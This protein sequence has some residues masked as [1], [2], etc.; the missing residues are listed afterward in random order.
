MKGSWTVF[1][2]LCVAFEGV[3]FSQGGGTSAGRTTPAAEQPT[4]NPL[5]GDGAA[6]RSGGS[7][8]RTRCAG[9]HGVD[10]AGYIGPDLTRL[11]VQGMIDDR[12]FETVRKGV[13]GTDMPPADPR[14][15]PDREIWE[16]LAYLRSLTPVA[17]IPETGNAENGQ[18][19]F[20]RNCQFCHMVGDTGGQLGPE[21]TRIGSGRPRAVLLSKVRGTGEGIRPGFEPVTLVLQNG[22]RLK[23]VKKNEDE[24][25]I[26]VMDLGQ[27]IQGYLKSDLRD[28][29]NETASVMP[30]YG[31]EQLNDRDLDDLLRY[32]GTLRSNSGRR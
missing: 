11:W 6:V 7:K 28:V 14:R 29:I 23:G 4:K 18:R 25:S 9:C 16:V 13:M 8:F 12:I 22:Q 24:F 20:Q 17:P 31:P 5:E 19:V 27:R 15:V 26:Q 32:L 1:V 30:V 21:L 3:A 10:A 2:L